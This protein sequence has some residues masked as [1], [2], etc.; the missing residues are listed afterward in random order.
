VRYREVFPAWTCSITPKTGTSNMT[1]S[2]AQGL[3]SG[4]HPH[5]GQGAQGID[6]ERGAGLVLETAAGRVLLHKPVAYQHG[7]G[8]N[9]KCLQL[10]S[11]QGRGSLCAR[12]V[13]PQPGG[14]RI[15]PVLFICGDAG[16]LYQL[17]CLWTGSGNSIR[18]R[19][20]LVSRISPQR[21]VRFSPRQVAMATALIAK[22]DATGSTLLFATYLGGSDF[23]SANSIAWTPAEM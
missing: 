4:L 16:C 10:C 15:D 23:D 13:R 17:H 1:S 9:G 12:R 20:I 19:L 7:P 2:F 18:G 21:Q 6:P 14:L 3:E 22:L 5:D 11:R 8:V